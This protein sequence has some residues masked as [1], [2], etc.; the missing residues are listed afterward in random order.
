MK[1]LAGVVTTVVVGLAT[2]AF[3]LGTGRFNVAA[4][5]A[6]DITDKVAPWVLE[7]SVKRAAR[8]IANPIATDAGAVARGLLHYREN[9]LPCHGA[10]GV[11]PVEFQ[12]GMNPTPPGIDAAILQDASDAELFW[13]VKNGIRMT[14]MPAFGVNRS[15]GEIRDIVAFVRHAPK[16][17]DEERQALTAP[18][19]GEEH[20]HEARPPASPAPAASASPPR[21][22]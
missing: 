3:V 14:G 2:G 13:V 10:P 4:T 19:V 17:T 12:E 11:D 6:P 5:A 22:D 21:H 8:D 1:F 15:D 9:C 18:S 7:K 16:V 20:H